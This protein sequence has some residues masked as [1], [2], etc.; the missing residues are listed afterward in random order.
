MAERTDSLPIWLARALAN[1]SLAVYVLGLL[2]IIATRVLQN[3][4]MFPDRFRQAVVVVALAFMVVTWIA[5]RRYSSS[6]ST[7]SDDGAVSDTDPEYPL[8]TRLSMAGAAVG[9]AFGI[10]VAFALDRYFLGGIF[11]LGAYMF[12]RMA[13]HRDDED[14]GY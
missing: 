9:V 6:G 1:Y 3:T 7:V 14:G 2:V 12:V 10:Y 13:Y 11:I 8:S 5:E 4:A